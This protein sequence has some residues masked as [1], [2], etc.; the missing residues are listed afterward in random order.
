[1]SWCLFVRVLLRDHLHCL[2]FSIFKIRKWMKWILT[3]PTLR[4]W[5]PRSNKFMDV[6]ASWAACWESN[7][8]KP[9]PLKKTEGQLF[10]WQNRHIFL[11]TTHFH[12]K[13]NSII[14][15]YNILVFSRFPSF[16][17]QFTVDN[18]SKCFKYTENKNTKQF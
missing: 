9:Y 1:M 2:D 7:S 15:N 6:T 10:T 18:F 4:Y 12:E 14:V 17:G 5:P 13:W 16:C 11:C 3:L 8:M